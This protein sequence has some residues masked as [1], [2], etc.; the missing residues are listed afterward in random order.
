MDRT[1]LSTNSVNPE[2]QQ[3]RRVLST[4]IWA[5]WGVYLFVIITALFYNDRVLFVATL[6][7]CTS[8]GVPLVLIRRRRLHAA[9]LV[10]LL[11]ELV[12]VTIIATVG[13]GIRDLA[14]LAFPIL[15]IFAGLALERPYFRISVG[16]TILAVCWLVFGEAFG[17]FVT[18]PF[19][20]GDTNWFY[21]VGMTLILLLAA[22]AV[23]LLATNMRKGLEQARAE[24]VQR[25]QAE[26]ALRVNESRLNLATSVGNIG[27]WDWNVVNDELIWADCMYS[28]YGIHKE[29]FSGAF[30]AWT[31]TLHP[32]DRKYA[33]AEIQA[34]LRGEREYAPEFRIVRPD[35]TDRVIKATSQTMRDQDGKA[36]RMIGTNIDITE[37]KQADR[38]LKEYSEHLAEMVEERTNDLRQAQEKIVRQEKLAVLGQMAGSVGHELRNPLGVINTSI[39]YL[40][41]VQPEADEKVRKHLDIIEKQVQTSDKII[42]DLLGFARIKG[43]EREQVS[44]PALV[45]KTLERFPV[46]AGIELSL[47]L[48]QDLPKVLVD[49]RQMEQVL[50]NLTTNACQAMTNKGKLALIADHGS[51]TSGCGLQ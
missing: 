36:L 22:L 44:V 49:P 50:G 41:M 8:L 27:I 10:V 21:L 42:G 3:L 40:K 26:E 14:M 51:L 18:K 12:T 34:A 2:D 5:S 35:G 33:E 39:Y 46:P 47:D 28:L 1:D 31:R 7:G 16:L 4:L 11:I 24:V 13:Q 45:K 19:V 37:R 29:D 6:A 43:A 30:E 38:Q 23:D 32:D 15:L 25:K 17:W 9:S 48:L 20:G